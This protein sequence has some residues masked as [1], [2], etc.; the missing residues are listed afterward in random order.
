M[1]QKNTS[2]QKLI[3]QRKKILNKKYLNSIK[4]FN[5]MKSISLL[6]YK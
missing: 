3:P 5:V 4:Q 2:K 6:G 1:V